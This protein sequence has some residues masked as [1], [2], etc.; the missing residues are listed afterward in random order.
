MN[1]E[2]HPTPR[3]ARATGMSPALFT[4]VAQTALAAATAWPAW[5]D[6]DVQ[7]QRLRPAPVMLSGATIRV[8]V[9]PAQGDWHPTAKRLEALLRA[10]LT[11]AYPGLREDAVRPDYTLQCNLL[12]LSAERKEDVRR[13]SI[14]RT[15]IEALKNLLQERRKDGPET[16]KYVLVSAD[17]S[18]SFALL[19]RDGAT[20]ASGNVAPPHFQKDYE[21][22]KGAPSLETVLSD[23]AETVSTSIAAEL[24]PRHESVP[25]RLS[26][27]GALGASWTLARA[28]QWFPYVESLTALPEKERDAAFESERRVNIGTAY[29]ALAYEAL[30]TDTERAQ[31]NLDQA[32]QFFREAQQRKPDSAAPAEGLR[33]VGEA[34][35]YAE[36]LAR[37]AGGGH[38]DAP[39]RAAAN[40]DRG[41]SGD[42]AATGRGLTNGDVIEMVKSGLP[43]D[44]VLR[45]VKESKERAFDVGARGLVEL[46][47]GGVSD[48][49]IRAMLSA[50]SAPAAQGKR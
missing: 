15:G 50:G 44:V 27:R 25:V 3:R 21:E 17:M 13:S 16:M 47:R 26:R 29:E 48:A 24:S 38:S 34:R 20:L 9:K 4:L 49:V 43:D 45:A 5:A 46:K 18:A 6:E 32:E 31:R 36:A 42:A 2:A 12:E 28:H 8:T 7:L 37:P 10:K 19:S 1:P 39:R 23:L 35:A 11:R 14:K 30:G 40:G 41:V 33:R 22:G